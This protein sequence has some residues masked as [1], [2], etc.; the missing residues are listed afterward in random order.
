MK[1]PLY[2]L[3]QNVIEMKRTILFGAIMA[4]SVYSSQAQFKISQDIVGTPVGAKPERTFVGTEYLYADFVKGHV[5]QAD[6]KY[7]NNMDLNYDVMADKLVFLRGGQEMAFKDPVKEFQLIKPKTSPIYLQVF[8]NGFPANGT[9]TEKSYYM[10]LNSGK[11]IALKKPVKSIVEV[12]PYGSAKVQKT[13]VNSE[14]YFIFSNGQMVKVKKDKKSLLNAL[15]DKKD[16]LT[17][18]V[19]DKKLSFKSDEDI[20]TLLEYYNTLSAS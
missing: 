9:N 7:F 15:A 13:V 1:N 12:T 6:G 5:L 3:Y 8:R 10:V 11:A 14:Q 2:L 16:S 20:R 4:M 19:D 17:R 18:F